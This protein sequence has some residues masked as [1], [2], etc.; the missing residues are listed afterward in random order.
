MR[1][2]TIMKPKQLEFQEDLHGE[3][4]ELMT[5]MLILIQLIPFQILS[6]LYLLIVLMLPVQ[7]HLSVED[8]EMKI[9]KVI[10]DLHYQ[11]QYSIYFEV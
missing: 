1:Q 3:L 2:I 9:C 6:L 5:I 8:S 10:D 4:E 7:L 11:I